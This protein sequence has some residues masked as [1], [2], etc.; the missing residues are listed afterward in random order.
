MLFQSTFLLQGVYIDDDDD[1][2]DETKLSTKGPCSYYGIVAMARVTKKKQ[3]SRKWFLSFSGGG[4]KKRVFGLP[5]WLLLLLPRLLLF[6]GFNKQ[7]Q[8]TNNNNKQE[9]EERQAK[10]E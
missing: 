8:Q 3:A 4:D 2:E 1:D 6:V 10:K 5:F 7:Q 9:E